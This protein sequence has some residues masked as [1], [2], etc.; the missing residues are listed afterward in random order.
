MW[1]IYFLI[2][3]RACYQINGCDVQDRQ[4]AFTL[5]S[6]EESRSIV[7]LVTRPE[8][9]WLDEEHNELLEELKMEIL[10]ERRNEEVQKTGGGEEQVRTAWGI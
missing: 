7:L 9:A 5:L 4:E 10:E 6:N 8:E 2:S 3:L 1:T